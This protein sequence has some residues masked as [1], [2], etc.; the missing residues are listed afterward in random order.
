MAVEEVEAAGLA[1]IAGIVPLVVAA[2][3]H[4]DLLVR[5]KFLD[6]IDDIIGKLHHLSLNDN[7]HN[8][9]FGCARCRLI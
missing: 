9:A 8:Q 7:G 4:G 1:R 3:R 2:H 5:A 6:P